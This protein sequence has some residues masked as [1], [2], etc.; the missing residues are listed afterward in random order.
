ML[1]VDFLTYN[2]YEVFELFMLKCAD[3]L[4]RMEL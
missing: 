1:V 4:R 3:V 2:R